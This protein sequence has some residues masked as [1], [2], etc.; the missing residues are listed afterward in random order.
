M[1]KERVVI[2]LRSLV[3]TIEAIPFVIM[4]YIGTLAVWIKNLFKKSLLNSSN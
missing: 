1:E 3:A 4:T 2:L